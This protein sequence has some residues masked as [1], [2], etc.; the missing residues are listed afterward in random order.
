MLKGGSSLTHYSLLVN[1]RIVGSVAV[2]GRYRVATTISTRRL[3][4][5]VFFG[6]VDPSPRGSTCRWSRP[7]LVRYFATM[8][9]RSADRSRLSC[10]IPLVLLIGSASVWPSTKTRLPG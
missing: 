1:G 6:S 4:S 7:W 10:H 2:A 3:A 8:R 9:A 5:L